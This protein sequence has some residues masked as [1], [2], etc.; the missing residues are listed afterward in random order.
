MPKLN[1]YFLDSVVI[2]DEKIFIRSDKLPYKVVNN[3]ENHCK[4]LMSIINE[5]PD[6]N[7]GC[8]SLLGLNWFWL[9]KD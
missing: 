9:R 5:H 8:I 7:F 1:V 2:E 3:W 6:D 4:T